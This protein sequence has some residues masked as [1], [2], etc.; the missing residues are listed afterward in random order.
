MGSYEVIEKALSNGVQLPVADIVKSSFYERKT[1][2]RS[3]LVL[4]KAGVIECV[5]TKKILSRRK[6]VKFY[7]QVKPM[8]GVC[9][10]CRNLKYTHALNDGVCNH[11]LLKNTKQ[12]S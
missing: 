9:T 4:T 1:I 10:Q 2:D 5:E 12:G 11:C 3:I 7:R 6:A 8:R